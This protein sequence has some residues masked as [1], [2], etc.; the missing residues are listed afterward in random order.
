MS[1]GG[2]SMERQRLKRTTVETCTHS[3]P[4]PTEIDVR[5]QLDRILASAEFSVPQR[6]RQFLIYVV[7]K[8]LAG[9]AERIKAYTIAVEVFGRDANFDVQN[10]PVVRIEAGRLRRALERYYLLDGHS[11]P[12]AIEI[13]KGGYVPT[14]SWRENPVDDRDEP[15]SLTP[16][17]EI[18][19]GPTVA[20]RQRPRWLAGSAIAAALA[21]VI[22][23]AWTADTPRIETA[24][25]A[26]ARPDAP[27][28]T[29]KRFANVSRNSEA[30]LYAA[31][32]QDE[33]LTQLARFKEMTVVRQDTS[34]RDAEEATTTPNQQQFGNRHVL[35]GGIRAADGKVRVTARLLDASTSAIVWTASYDTEPGK[36]GGVEAEAAIASKIATVVAQPYG[37]VFSLPPQPAL[38]RNAQSLEAAACAHRFY[39]YRMGL[40]FAEHAQMRE[41]LERA[42]ALYPEH[43]TTWA[44][45]AYLYLDEDRFQLNRRPGSPKPLERARE[46]AKQAVRLDPENV[47]ALQALMSVLYFSREPAEALKLGAQA[48]AINPN[49]TELLGE[50]GS[51]LA[52][53]GEWERGAAMLDEALA[54]NPGHSDYYIG[55]LA[56]AAYMQGDDPRSVDLIRRANQRQFSIYHFVAALIFARSGLQAEA[57][58]SRAQFLK[59]RPNFFDDFDG[60][61]DKR[62]FIPRDR[63]ILLRGAIQAGFPVRPRFAAGSE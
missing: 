48:I 21:C 5:T 31:G 26:L 3:V 16:P 55:L 11:A 30:D 42:V 61:L 1:A 35:E 8:A 57:A 54:R 44:M 22:A 41:C 34:S 50:F 19:P 9:E 12:V 25:R 56:L 20:G 40:G 4:G 2:L 37:V 39:Q 47:R 28:L 52:Q 27:I 43:S 46:A 38:A 33:L 49:D 18:G 53:S 7:G 60:E 32:L 15:A 36:S 13:P 24:A 45:L 59:L 23:I 6:V 63:A 10:D 58:Q 17:G 14:F 62:N 29:V 51:R